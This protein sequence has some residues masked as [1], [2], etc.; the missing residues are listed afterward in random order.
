MVPELVKE[1]TLVPYQGPG[2]SNHEEQL[3]CLLA[4]KR[5]LSCNN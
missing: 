1:E 4:N 3:A 5:M 2:S